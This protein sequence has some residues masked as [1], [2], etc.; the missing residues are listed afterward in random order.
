MRGQGLPVAGSGVKPK[1]LTKPR[2]REH[3]DA[4]RRYPDFG[5]RLPC[6]RTAMAFGSLC[7]PPLV[8]RRCRFGGLSHGCRP[9]RVSRCRSGG[10][11]GDSCRR[12][13][14]IGRNQIALAPRG[15][16][17]GIRHP[18]RHRWLP[19]CTWCCRSLWRWRLESRGSIGPC[20][21]HHRR[22]GLGWRATDTQPILTK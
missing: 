10:G 17:A 21:Y 3:T 4:N 6:R 12:P 22:H 7:A 20:G 18:R 9:S 16:R 11:N 13:L 15:H 1:P 2:L 5:F 14:D 8:R 19:C